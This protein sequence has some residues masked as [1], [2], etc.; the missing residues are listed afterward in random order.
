MSIWNL[1]LMVCFA[2]A[3]GGVVNAL[4]TDNGFILPRTETAN[5]VKIIRP[6]V[7]GNIIIGAVAAGISWGLY[8]PFN[9]AVVFGTTPPSSDPPLK[10]YLTLAALV[11]AVLVGI[12]GAKWLTNE[13]DKKLLRAAASEAA[14]RQQQPDAA[15]GIMLATPA[16]ALSIAQAS[17]P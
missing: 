8:G 9:L 1:L 12:A 17:R 5:Q 10:P 6:G 11:G 7:I 4:L 3:F 14:S 13:V 2:G 15:R 16:D